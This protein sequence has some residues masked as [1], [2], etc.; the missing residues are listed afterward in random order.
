M[1]IYP[2]IELS[3]KQHDE[4]EALRNRSFLIIK[5]L[6]LITSNFRICEL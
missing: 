4:I 3:K 6:A 2:E 1:E 5:L